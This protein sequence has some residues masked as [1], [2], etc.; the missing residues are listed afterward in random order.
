[1]SNTLNDQ[2]ADYWSDIQALSRSK[3]GMISFP[4]HIKNEMANLVKGVDKIALR[5]AM[6]VISDS[7]ISTSVMRKKEILKNGK[8]P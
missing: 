1:M 5:D 6:E 8:L 2:T 3:I 7:L 4:Q